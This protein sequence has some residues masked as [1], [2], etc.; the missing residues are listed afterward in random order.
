MLDGE[1]SMNVPVAPSIGVVPAN[2]WYDRGVDPD[3]ATLNVALDPL[4][5]D[6]D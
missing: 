6:C 2:H 5:M 4:V 3:A 1:T